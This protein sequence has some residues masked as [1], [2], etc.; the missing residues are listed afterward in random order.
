MQNKTIFITGANGEIGQYLINKLN[1]NINYN[2]IALDLNK[3]F[4]HGKVKKYIQGSVID[5]KL[6]KL[7]FA[8]HDINVII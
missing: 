4:L 3:R 8:T 5:E 6:I 1:N 7:I 2:I